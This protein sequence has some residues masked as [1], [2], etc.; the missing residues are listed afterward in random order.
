MEASEALLLM[1]MLER[2]LGLLA[3]GLG[4]NIS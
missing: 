2:L 1:R 4:S 3:G